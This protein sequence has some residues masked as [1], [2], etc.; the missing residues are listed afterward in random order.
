MA[1]VLIIYYTRSGNTEKLA[2]LIEEGIKSEGVDSVLKKVQD[3]EPKEMLEYDGIVI[4]SPVYY[5]SVAAEIKKLFD[6]SVKFH[7]QLDGKVGAAFSSSANIAGGNET[8]ILDILAAMLIHG[9]IIQGDPKG[10]HYGS[11][12][13]STPDERAKINAVRQGQR[14]AKLVK[15]ISK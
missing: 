13:I 7:S 1:K 15:Q 5:G 4:G 2:K 9:M 8:T 14:I 10:D 12:S 3:V 11:V 6:D